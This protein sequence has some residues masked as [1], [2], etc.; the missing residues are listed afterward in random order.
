MALHSLFRAY[1][2]GGDGYEWATISTVSGGAGTS[3]TGVYCVTSE[4]GHPIAVEL[5]GQQ[6]IP[7]LVGSYLRDNYS[8]VIN[9][10]VS[11]VEAVGSKLYLVKGDVS[12]AFM[13]P[14]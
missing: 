12:L 14:S 2:N 3:A 7:V 13:G 10:N 4:D 11:D 6:Q 1:I 9:E 5:S 8:W